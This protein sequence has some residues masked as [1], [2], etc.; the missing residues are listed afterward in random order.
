[1]SKK[2]KHNHHSDHDD[3]VYSA[4][5]LTS[6]QKLA[7]VI[8]ILKA[9][10]EKIKESNMRIKEVPKDSIDLKKEY[11]T[12]DTYENNEGSHDVEVIKK[13]DDIDPVNNSSKLYDTE[14]VI[15][16]DSASELEDRDYEIIPSS[17]VISCES[18]T[19]ELVRSEE[20]NSNLSF[21]SG[22][23]KIPIVLSEFEMHIF[24]EA[25]IKFPE[26]VFQI[27]SLEKSVFLSK[28]DLILGTD[29]LFIKGFL[30]EDIEYATASNIRTHTISGDIKKATFNIP[31]QCSTK[32]SFTVPPIIRKDLSMIE[33]EVINPDKNGTDIGEKDYE[34][35]KFLNEKIYCKL[36]EIK[37]METNIK[38]NISLLQDT[39][40]DAETF[41]GMRKKVIL[42]L[43]LSLIQNQEIFNQ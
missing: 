12:L 20:L 6:E 30:K 22:V 25:L 16:E 38:E 11:N 37:I 43:K 42:A 17:K 5:D 21:K 33:L 40:E 31:L 9:L 13:M 36:N 35:F 34:Y 39:L 19:I 27:K 3:K 29:K 15:E 10:I 26:P 2:H 24:I 41:K 23:A 1:M 7:A 14:D 8:I 18:T 28:C 32:V 4:E